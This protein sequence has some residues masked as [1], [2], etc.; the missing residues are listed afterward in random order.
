MDELFYFA[1]HPP[2]SKSF[3]ITPIYKGLL[4]KL[5]FVPEPFHKIIDARRQPRFFSFIW[6]LVPWSFAPPALS[7][8][9][10]THP[11]QLH[12]PLGETFSENC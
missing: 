3:K 10:K 2:I 8:E 11:P 7:P 1:A 6:T 9:R 4:T 5:L 12:P